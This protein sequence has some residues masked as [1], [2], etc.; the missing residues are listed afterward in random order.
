MLK[1]MFADIEYCLITHM[2][3]MYIFK[4]N[5]DFFVVYRLPDDWCFDYIH[6]TMVP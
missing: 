5:K 2:H 3:H 6:E 4:K 1:N